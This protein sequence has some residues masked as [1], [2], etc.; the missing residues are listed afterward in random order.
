MVLYHM[1]ALLTMRRYGVNQASRFVE[2]IWLHPK[3]H[4]IR[5]FFFEKDLVY[6]M[7]AQREMSNHLI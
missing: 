7:G 2:G 3:S 4:Q 1:V 5:F 6:N